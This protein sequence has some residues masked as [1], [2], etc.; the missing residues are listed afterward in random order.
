MDTSYNLVAEKCA[1]QM[2]EYQACVE[3]NQ[4]SDWPT[5]C[6]PQSRALSLCADTAVPHLAEVKS[7]CAG[8][9][10][11]YRACLDRNASKSD[12]EVERACTGLMR[13]VWECSE[14]VMNEVK[15]R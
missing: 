5:I 12:E 2:A 1:K 8:S 3:N 14:R 9:I 4:S 11:S 15:G 7:E 13:G 6:L 10:A